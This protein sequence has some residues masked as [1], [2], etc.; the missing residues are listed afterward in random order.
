M[1][2]VLFLLFLGGNWSR[3]S[4]HTGWDHCYIDKLCS[5]QRSDH[6]SILLVLLVLVRV[7]VIGRQFHGAVAVRPVGQQVG[8]GDGPGRDV[9]RGVGRVGRG[10]GGGR[11]D[12]HQAGA[13]GKRGAAGAECAGVTE[14]LEGNLNC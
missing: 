2:V 8:R 6:L 1:W 11:G 10:G 9:G 4:G 12:V 5:P 7:G 14:K 13:A 3:P